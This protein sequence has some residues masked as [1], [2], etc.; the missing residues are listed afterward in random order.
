MRSVAPLHQD[1][2]KGKWGVLAEILSPVGML[3]DRSLRSLRMTGKG[4]VV[5]AEILQSL[6]S[7]RMTMRRECYGITSFRM[8]MWRGMTIEREQD[9][10]E[11]RIALRLLC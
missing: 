4:I 7:F 6:R 10:N 3:R 11:R 8:I 9:N 5:L 1:D 2:N